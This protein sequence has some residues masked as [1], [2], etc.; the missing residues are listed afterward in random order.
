MDCKVFI[1]TSLDGYIATP[2]G[3]IDWLIKASGVAPK[4]EDCGYGELMSSIDVLIMGRNSFEKVL[5]FESWPYG[6]KPV[7][8]MSQKGVDIPE[9]L[10]NTVSQSTESP[11]EIVSRL[12]GEGIKGA[13]IDGGA[14]IQSFL[15]AGLINEMIITIVPIIL[16]K[17]ISLFGSKNTMQK[18][19]LLDC[20][21]YEFGFVQF[22]YEPIHS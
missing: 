10:E 14:V 6:E 17:G 18:L 20:K 3:G 9:H 16:G 11:T 2:D 22:K 8:V 7:I 21:S 5:T 15:A 12:E 4:G 19:R 1:A 13:Y